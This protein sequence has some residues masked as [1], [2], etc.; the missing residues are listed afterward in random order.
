MTSWFGPGAGFTDPTIGF[1]PSLLHM[2]IAWGTLGPR[3]PRLL[4]AVK[5]IESGKITAEKHITQVL[6][7]EKT[8]EAFDLA[9]DSH[10]EIK[11]VVEI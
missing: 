9:T 3:V 7:L 4:E 8:K 1:D 10:D 5:L 2:Q 6:P 11:V